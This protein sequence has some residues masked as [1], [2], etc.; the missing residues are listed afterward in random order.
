MIERYSR[1]ALFVNAFLDNCLIPTFMQSVQV[2][3]CTL[4][5]ATF[6]GYI[7]HY[8]NMNRILAKEYPLYGM[9][10][11]LPPPPPPPPPPPTAIF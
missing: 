4:V 1:H 7:E 10:A 11:Q 2:D 8:N 5:S 9:L 6:P 3:I